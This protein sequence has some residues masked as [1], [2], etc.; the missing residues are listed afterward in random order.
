MCPTH[1]F[2][3]RLPSLVG[4]KVFER[5][6][7]MY[8]GCDLSLHKHRVAFIEPGQHKKAP[9]LFISP[10]DICGHHKECFPATRAYLT[11]HI[12]VALH[13]CHR[14]MARQHTLQY[15]EKSQTLSKVSV[16]VKMNQ[17]PGREKKHVGF[18]K[19]HDC[20]SLATAF[21]IL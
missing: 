14:E 12:H 16:H 18:F 15:S 4:Q 11:P 1:S 5:L 19:V 13:V 8:L 2:L 9:S 3:Q 7:S 21:N 20:L 10:P 6:P 17:R